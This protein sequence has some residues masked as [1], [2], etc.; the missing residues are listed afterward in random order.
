MDTLGAVF[1]P[2]IA[3]AFLYVFPGQY[4]WLFLL[5]FLPGVMTIF[6]TRLVKEGPPVPGKPKAVSLLHAFHYWKQS[7]GHYR[8]LVSGL[9]VFALVN[10]SDLLLLLKIRESGYSDQ[11]V[12]GLYIFYNLIYALMAY[13]AGKL[14]DRL[15]MRNVFVAGLALFGLT[16]TGFAFQDNVYGY[17]FLFTCYGA[18]AA[19]TEG[20]AKA[21]ISRL[22]DPTETATAIGTY[23]GFQ[24]IAALLASSLAGAA[25]YTFGPAWAFGASG[26]VAIML[27][28]YF[29]RLPAKLP[30]LK[31]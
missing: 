29:L 13:P 9:L 7:P 14:A 8:A 4:Q 20:V 24:S 25:W 6:L 17:L 31:D 22:V 16:Y 10:S 2:L 15:G 26:A 28:F 27:I 21:W 1:G 30:T 3:L 11:Q 23:T 18:Y 5:A 19:A 12:I